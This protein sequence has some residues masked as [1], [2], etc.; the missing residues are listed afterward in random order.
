MVSKVTVEA[1]VVNLMPDHGRKIHNKEI[2]GLR[3]FFNRR[4]RNQLRL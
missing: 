1:E 3:P 4:L 2:T